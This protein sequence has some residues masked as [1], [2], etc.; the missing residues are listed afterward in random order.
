MYVV[1]VYVS[2]LKRH[3]KFNWKLNNFLYQNLNIY[4]FPLKQNV[5]HDF[6]YMWIPCKMGGDRQ[7]LTLVPLALPSGMLQA[8]GKCSYPLL[9]VQLGDVA[10]GIGSLEW[11]ILFGMIG[12]S[13]FRQVFLRETCKEWN[14]NCKCMSTCLHLYVV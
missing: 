6:F 5:V 4:V 3:I 7:K 13:C 9:L 8:S 12:K 14:N 2:Y 10:W 1:G 11:D